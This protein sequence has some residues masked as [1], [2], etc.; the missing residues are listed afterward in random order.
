VALGKHSKKFNVKNQEDY[1]ERRS[2]FEKVLKE[3]FKNQEK[4]IDYTK[5]KE[6][7]KKSFK[8]S[9]IN[10]DKFL[11]EESRLAIKKIISNFSSV[12]RF[13]YNFITFNYTNILEKCLEQ[14]ESRN[15]YLIFGSDDSNNDVNSKYQKGDLIYVHGTLDDSLILGV[16]NKSQIANK[17]LAENHDFQKRIIKSQLN[18]GTGQLHEDGAKKLICQSKIICL[19]GVSIGET[20]KLWWKVIYDWLKND[21][22]NQLIIFY[23]DKGYDKSD[24]AKTN[25]YKDKRRNDFYSLAE[26]KDEDKNHVEKRIHI[27]YGGEM[28]KIDFFTPGINP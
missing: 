9:L 7:I 16:D 10:Y 26:T 3:H 6:K 11:E 8:T 25:S 12:D 17:E 5:N 1:F 23:F 22:S 13:V 18:S 15:K 27:A 4:R 14:I 19:F 24:T 21:K 28:F 20:D 2:S